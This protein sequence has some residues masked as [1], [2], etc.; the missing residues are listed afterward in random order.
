MLKIV[1]LIFSVAYAGDTAPIDFTQALIGPFG[2]PLHKPGDDCK[3]GQMPGRDC[4]QADMTLGDAA[5]DALDGYLDSDKGEEPTRKFARDQLA[6]RLY[7]N[8]H[9]ILTSEELVLLKDR[10]GRVLGT[11]QVGAAWRLID[12]SEK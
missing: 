10:I 9:A 8:K 3:F 12:P 4:S 6:R 7:G 1:A 11:A 2:V 5:V